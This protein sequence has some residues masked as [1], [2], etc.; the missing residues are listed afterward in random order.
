MKMLLNDHTNLVYWFAV[1]SRPETKIRLKPFNFANWKVGSHV[2]WGEKGLFVASR[3][4]ELKSEIYPL[5]NA[6]MFWHRIFF[7]VIH[8]LP[9]HRTNGVFIKFFPFPLFSLNIIFCRVWVI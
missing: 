3:L 2:N 7:F 4:E 6:H 5:H 1:Q 8:P 9:I